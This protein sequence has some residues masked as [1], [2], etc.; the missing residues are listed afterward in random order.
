LGFLSEKGR[1]VFELGNKYKITMIEADE[2]C[3]FY[4]D[5]LE[6]Y[7]PLIRVNLGK[8]DKVINI[9]SK[10]FVSAERVNSYYVKQIDPSVDTAA[11]LAMISWLNILGDD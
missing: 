10:S 7:L 5:I 11:N 8:T 6:I 9:S 2:K 3:I 1:P 4:A